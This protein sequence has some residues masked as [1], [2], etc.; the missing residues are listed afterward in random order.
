MFYISSVSL[1]LYSYL[2]LFTLMFLPFLFHLHECSYLSLFNLSLFN[3]DMQNLKASSFSLKALEIEALISL[4]SNGFLWCHKWA[5]SK[6]VNLTNVR[7]FRLT[8]QQTDIRV[9]REVAYMI[10]ISHCLS[11]GGRQNI[12]R[13]AP[14]FPGLLLKKA[15]MTW[16]KY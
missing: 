12:P 9:H 16:R 7:K 8:N 3:L 10:L 15:E 13:V 4:S 6:I 5:F 11:R 1:L 14:T 2:S